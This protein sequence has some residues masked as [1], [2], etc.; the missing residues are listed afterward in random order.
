[1]RKNKTWSILK[2]CVSI[3]LG[4][5]KTKKKISQHTLSPDWDLNKWYS[6][7]EEGPLHD[8]RYHRHEGKRKCLH[9]FVE[10]MLG[11]QPHQIPGR[12]WEDN[13]RMDLSETYCVAERSM[14]LAQGHIQWRSLSLPVLSLRLLLS[15]RWSVNIMLY[16]TDNYFYSW[17]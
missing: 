10:N 13:I 9:S 17:M 15:D 5:R 12:R 14:E 6:P 16:N 4:L 2:C 7:N 8:A 11:K 1:V 3:F